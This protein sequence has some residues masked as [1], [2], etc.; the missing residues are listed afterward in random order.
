MLQVMR[1][2]VVLVLVVTFPAAQLFMAAGVALLG[3]TVKRIGRVL[4]EMAVADKVP[5]EML[6]VVTE[7]Q[8]PVVEVAAD[9]MG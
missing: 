1:H 5:M 7:L 3:I 8:T 2:Q 4:V 9:T 6:Q